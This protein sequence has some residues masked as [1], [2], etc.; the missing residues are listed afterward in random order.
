MNYHFSKR[1]ILITILT[2]NTILT[3]PYCFKSYT[4]TYMLLA[5]LPDTTSAWP[6]M[7]TVQDR[8]RLG[9]DTEQCGRVCVVWTLQQEQ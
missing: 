4:P 7:L 3:V 5:P 8:E 1:L 2:F 6:A 9:V